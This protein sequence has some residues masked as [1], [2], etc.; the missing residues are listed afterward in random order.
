MSA[1]TETAIQTTTAAGSLRRYVVDG[2][3]LLLLAALA[4]K[5]TY[6]I[7]TIRDVGLADEAW[8]ISTALAIPERGLPNAEAAPLYCLWYYAVSLLQPDPI[9]LYYLSWKLLVLLLGLSAYVLGRALGGGRFTS[10]LAAFVVLTSQFVDVWPYPMHLA[11]VILAIGTAVAVHFSTL[12]ASLATVAISL[13]LAS[14]V[15]PELSVAFL[16]CIAFSVALAGLMLWRRPGAWRAWMMSGVA[17]GALT[18]AMVHTMGNPLAGGRSFYA[19]GQHYAANMAEV[20]KLDGNAWIY[21]DR[22]VQEDFGNARTPIQASI[23]N[24]RAML[25]HLSVNARKLPNVIVSCGKPNLGLPDRAT[26]FFVYVL[27]FVLAVAGLG[28]LRRLRAKTPGEPLRI[29][30]AMLACLAVP[31]LASALIVAPRP[32]YLLPVVYFVIVL[33][34]V[35]IARLPLTAGVFHRLDHGLALATAG[36]LM[37]AMMPNRAH[38]FALQ[39]GFAKTAALGSTRLAVKQTA[40][41]IRELGIGP[42]A[43]FLDFFSLSHALYAGLPTNWVDIAHKDRGFRDFVRMRDISVIILDPYL[44]NDPKYRDDPEFRALV[45]GNEDSDFQ[46]FSVDGTTVRIAV[47]RNVLRAGIPR[48]EHRLQ[49]RN[50]GFWRFFS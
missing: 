46:L 44:L 24:P 29:A 14:F 43:V 11:V 50:R 47:R 34:G 18:I 15:R 4:F 27:L 28:I 26:A 7:D 45:A 2:Y 10:L 37:L 21:W 23:A 49:S 38:G 33:A 12:P 41:L 8:Y 19:F 25:W 16:A 17:V 9:C 22:I 3:V 31:I 32:H 39:N 6:D 30:L 35:G 13:L 36:A 20:K 40:L 42:S 5:L 48:P 1:G